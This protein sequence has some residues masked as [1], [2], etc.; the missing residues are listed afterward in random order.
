MTSS[1][2]VGAHCQSTT[3]QQQLPMLVCLVVCREE[4]RKEEVTFIMSDVRNVREHSGC[5]DKTY[6]GLHGA[7][8]CR[9]G[10]HR[11]TLQ[12]FAIVHQTDIPLFLQVSQICTR[13]LQLGSMSFAWTSKTRARPF[14]LST[15]SFPCRNLAAATRCTWVATAALQVQSLSQSQLHTGPLLSHCR[16]LAQ[17]V[18]SSSGPR[19]RKL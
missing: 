17:S 6:I 19:H 9:V 8:L 10:I 13:L 4:V 11:N 12:P 3:V 18:S 7:N 2:W 1:G 16:T 15:T 5:E 14:T